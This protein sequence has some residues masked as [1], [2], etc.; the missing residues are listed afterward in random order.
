MWVRLTS[1]MKGTAIVLPRLGASGK[2]AR[3]VGR[4][5]ARVNA[6][7]GV[8]P[9]RSPTVYGSPRCASPFCSPRCSASPWAA[10]AS[11]PPLAHPDDGAPPGAGRALPPPRGAGHHPH[12]R[13][14]PGG[15]RRPPDRGRPRGVRSR[16]PRRGHG[17]RRSCARPWSRTTDAACA[18]STWIARACS[19]PRTST[20][21]T[22]RPPTTTSSAPRST[23][24]T[25]ARSP[26][27][28][29]IARTSS[30]SPT[31]A[32]SSSAGNPSATTPCGSRRSTR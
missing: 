31:C 2:G 16:R 32:S 14:H 26:R 24:A 13:R 22:W 3:T 28:R 19:G 17:P 8:A 18:P 21:G 1:V 6:H 27:A 7:P 15:G 9:G 10:V 4:R 25:P 11:R 30:T 5:I 12:P 29:W 20:P 23:S